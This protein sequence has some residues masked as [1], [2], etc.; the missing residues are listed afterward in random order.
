VN[1]SPNETIFESP[2]A[3]PW[4]TLLWLAVA[5][6]TLLVAIMNRE[7]GWGMAAVF[8]GCLAMLLFRARPRA[9]RVTLGPEALR[10][11]PGAITIPL[12]SIE[13]MT[14]AGVPQAPQSLR[15]TGPVVVMH[16]AG[17]TEFP[18]TLAPDGSQLYKAVL[19][20]LQPSGRRDRKSVLANECSS[21][22]EKFG[23]QRV[24]TY[25]PRSHLGRRPTW[26]RASAVAAAVVA[27]GFVTMAIAIIFPR[28]RHWH[29]DAAAGFSFFALFFGT[30]FFFIARQMQKYPAP[31][32]PNWRQAGLLISPAG[33]WLVQNDLSG[34]L[35][36]NEI[37]DVRL[38]PRERWWMPRIR[39]EMP[40]M[41]ELIIA[42]GKINVWDVY[43]RPLP[44]IADVISSLWRRPQP[45]PIKDGPAP[46][47]ASG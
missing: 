1:A 18:A 16:R 32:L 35:A 13:A 23:A 15:F 42:G 31:T 4:G 41:L 14:L 47:G 28:N 22:E 12:D 43:D 3:F 29:P 21:Q 27:A 10:I 34:F 30:L 25:F 20:R 44:V 36:W 45:A 40:G 5:G 33:L 46:T 9:M 38:N 39:R 7:L 26:R 8:A 17:V 11:E 2:R 37:L 19:G 6:V 24:W